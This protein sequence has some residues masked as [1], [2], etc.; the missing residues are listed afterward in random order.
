MHFVKPHI[1]ISEKG[2]TFRQHIQHKSR[3]ATIIISGVMDLFT[4]NAT[5][6]IV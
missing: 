5:D 4:D 3:C 6:H 1:G 2:S